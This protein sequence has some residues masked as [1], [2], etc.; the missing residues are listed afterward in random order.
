MP[1]CLR[2]LTAVAVF[3]VVVSGN[4][5]SPSSA[6]ATASQTEAKKPVFGLSGDA[7][8][9]TFLIKPDKTADFETVLG[10]L[11]ERPRRHG[12]DAS[13]EHE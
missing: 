4:L 3:T 5:A 10:R 1:R 13:I 7:A 6:Q 9:V 12:T 11:K 8:I 2:L